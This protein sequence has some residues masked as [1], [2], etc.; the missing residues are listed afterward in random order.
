MSRYLSKRLEDLEEYVPGEQPRDKKYIKLNTNE[1]PF[2]PSPAVYEVLSRSAADNLRLYS[3]PCCTSLTETLCGV[4][5]LKPENVVFGNGSDEILSFA[6]TAFC[7]SDTPAVFA[8]I[9]YGFYKVFAALNCI[10]FRQIP[11]KSDFSICPEDYINAGGT[12]FIANPNAPTGLILTESEIR[13]ILEGNPDNVVVIDEAYI[14]FGGQSMLPLIGE[15]K[16]LLIV[17]TFSKSRSLAGARLGFAA[18]CPELIADLQK[19]RNS[20]NPYNINRLT[21]A[22]GEAVLKDNEYFIKCTSEIIKNRT[23]M[24]DGLK[25]LGFSVIPSSANFVFAKHEAYDGGMLYRALK[26]KGVLVRHFDA[27]RISQYNR[28]TVGSKAEADAL[29][30][31]ADE[32]LRM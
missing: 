19:I 2:P 8:D 24:T 25:S 32:I 27:P 5:G 15:Y 20:N 23:Y 16:N 10:P 1:S 4:Y 30:K 28:I 22:L 29:L 14:D 6:F 18:G 31:A 12:I 7:D 26:N 21:Q 9:T 11:L 13:R 17:Q 3:D